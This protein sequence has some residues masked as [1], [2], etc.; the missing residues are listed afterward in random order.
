MA[1]RSYHIPYSLNVTRWQA[2]V[3]LPWLKGNGMQ[4]PIKISTIVT[5]A[6]LGFIIP[7]F[8]YWNTPISEGGWFGIL[9]MLVGWETMV[10]ILIAPQ[11]N[12]D[13]GYK[14]IIP[15]I[16]YWLYVHNRVIKTG[17]D[18]NLENAIDL[19]QIKMIDDRGVIT[20]NNGWVGQ[21]YELD[22]HGSNMLF[23]NE[24]DYVV[25]QF[26]RWLSLLPPNVS[27]TIPTQYTSLDLGSQIQDAEQLTQRQ[28]SMDL[29]A[30]AARKEK[31][32]RE[33]VSGN[34]R[35]RSI[36]QAIIISATDRQA[37][38]EQCQWFEAQ[39][40]SGMAKSVKRSG[41]KRTMEVTRSAIAP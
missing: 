20:F 15:T 2:P 38:L 1:K 11:E 40:Q 10:Y 13:A 3:I 30:L 34:E 16:S 8:V 27:I 36:T 9:M 17:G 39:V 21:M 26:E 37:L 23:D 33:N 19:M 35:F 32:L 24:R 5:L 22:G 7:L 12:G 29:R 6:F 18:A 25:D 31:V 14:S 41:F 28:S 4:R